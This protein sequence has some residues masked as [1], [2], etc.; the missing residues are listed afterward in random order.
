[1]YLHSSV[2]PMLL[3]ISPFLGCD[4]R[5]RPV[6]AVGCLFGRR[7]NDLRELRD[8]GDAGSDEEHRAEA[9]LQK[10]TDA[11]IAE[12]DELLAHKEAEI[13]EV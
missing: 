9:E 6:Q 13:L 10:V 3:G 5:S 11:K 12:L 8:A 4:S 1:M 7:S 2:P